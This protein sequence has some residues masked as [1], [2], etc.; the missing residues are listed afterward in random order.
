MVKR[1]E[2]PQHIVDAAMEL[3]AER[4][5]RGLSLGEV[6]VRARLPLAE[7][8]EHF[9]TKADILVGFLSRLDAQVLR[10]EVEMGEPV[11]DRL[12]D[13]VMRRFEAMAPHKPA[14]RAILRES[15]DDPYTL[16]CGAAR[17]FRSMALMLEAAGISASGLAGVLRVEG[18]A[19]IYL[20]IFRTWLRDDSPD[21]AKTMASLDRYLRRAEVFVANFRRRRA[22][23]G[24]AGGPSGDVAV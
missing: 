16:F 13:V 5:W 17:F 18:L 22:E 4:G 6:A 2:I 24:P 8:V 19:A 20:L 21:M 9:E 10:G 12:F 1:K 15:G 11:R 14:V 23:P 7:V 3:V